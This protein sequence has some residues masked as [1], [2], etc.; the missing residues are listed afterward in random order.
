MVQSPAALAD[1]GS[2]PLELKGQGKLSL[3]LL[4]L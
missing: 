3:G 2:T 4:L 1:V